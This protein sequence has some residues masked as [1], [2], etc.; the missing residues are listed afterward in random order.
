MV[1]VWLATRFWGD[2][3]HGLLAGFYAAVIGH[4]FPAWLGF[5]GGKGVTTAGVALLAID[6]PVGVAGCLDLPC[7]LR[8]PL[9][10]AR[11]TSGAAR[12]TA[13][14]LVPADPARLRSRGRR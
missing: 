2:S 7:R 14:R 13:L 10:V 3:A 5:K 8:L 12:R 11:R 9:L 4:N 1:A 6:W